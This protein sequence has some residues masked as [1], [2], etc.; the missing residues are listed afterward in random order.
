[1]ELFLSAALKSECAE[2][3]RHA[4][5]KVFLIELLSVRLN[6]GAMPLLVAC[7]SKIMHLT[8]AHRA[9]PISTLA[10]LAVPY[11]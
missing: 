3:Q 6:C 10:L 1:M 7:R 4:L 5:M 11:R 8:E 9:P 2:S